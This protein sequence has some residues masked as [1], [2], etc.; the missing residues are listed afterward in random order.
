[1]EVDL[2]EQVEEWGVEQVE[3]L[4]AEPAG[5]WEE[6]EEWEEEAEWATVRV[7][8]VFALHVEP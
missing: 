4:G 5:E 6:A 7:E 1:M 3:E 2:W 8:N